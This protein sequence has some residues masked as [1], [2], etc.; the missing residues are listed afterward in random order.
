MARLSVSAMAALLAALLF[1]TGGADAARPLLAGLL[2]RAPVAAGLPA[3]SALALEA[4]LRNA[5]ELDKTGT[6]IDDE[7]AAIERE[8]AEAMFLEV[9]INAELPMLG[10]YDEP[11]LNGFQKRVIRHE[12]LAKKFKAEF[13]LYQQRQN[14]YDAAVAEF[15]RDCARDFTASDR[16]AVK[17]KLGIK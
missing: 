7:I 15:D 8:T 4:C 5:G 16:D 14:A 10:G 12:E 3:M 9:Q 2:A 11:G 6:A 1:G 17:A 13:P